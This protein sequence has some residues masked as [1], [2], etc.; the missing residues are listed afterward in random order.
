MVKKL[1]L[2]SNRYILRGE[3]KYYCL[4]TNLNEH[5]LDLKRLVG[6][7]PILFIYV[8]YVLK[9]M[10]IITLDQKGGQGGRG[11]NKAKEKYR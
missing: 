8:K 5:T 2:L 7:G 10:I 3:I 4:E 6:F 1:H 11:I 9:H